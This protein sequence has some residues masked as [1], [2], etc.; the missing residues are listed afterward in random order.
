MLSPLSHPA[1]EI[2]RKRQQPLDVFFEPRNVALIGASETPGSVGRTLLQNLRAS[3][4]GGTVFPVNLKRSNV[5]GIKAY[6]S[7]KKLPEPADL[8]VIATPAPTVPGLIEECVAA[9]VKAAIIISAGFKEVG[10]AGIELEHT[11]LKTARAGKLRLIGPNCLGVMRPP[12]G[13]NATFANGIAAPGSVAFISQSG[14]LCTSILDWS[15]KENVGF[16]AFISVGS[17]LDVGWGDLID[18]LGDDPQTKSIL[19]YM[20]SIGDARA[21]LSAAR[22]VALSKPI[23]VIKAGRTEQAAKAA[24]SHTGSLAGSDAVLDAAFRRSGVLRVNRI[25]DLFYMAEVLAKQPRPHGPRLMILTNAGGPGVLATDAVIGEGLQLASLSKN[26]LETLNNQLPVAWSHSNPIDLLGDAPPERFR[27]SIQVVAK[28]ANSDGLLVILTPQAMTDPTATAQAVI[29]A[30]RNENK[31]LLTSWMGGQDVAAAND[32][33]AKAHIPTFP[34]PDTAVRAF[35]YM[36]RYTYNLRGLYETPLGARESDEESPRH[37]DVQKIFRSVLAD[38]RTLLTEVEAKRV[39]SAYGLPTVKTQAAGSVAEAVR[40][41]DKQGY[42]VVVKLLSHRITHKSDVGGVQLN[43]KSASEV[44]AA[45]ERIQKNVPDKDF[46][47]VSVQAMVP[48]QGFE[49][50]LGS[51]IDPQFGPVLLFGLGGTLVEVFKDRA[52]ALPPLTTVLARRMMEQTQVYTALK[53]IRG[54]KSVDLSALE[55]LLVQFS[56]LVSEHPRIKEIDINPLQAS[57]RGI[58]ALDAR[59]VIHPSSLTDAQLP[60]PAIRP[61]PQSYVWLFKSKKGARYTLRPIRPEDE[62]L[63]VR[64]HETLS[65]QSVYRR[66]LHQISLDQRTAHERLIRVC[67]NDYDR[68]LALVAETRDPQTKTRVLG[69]IARLIKLPHSTEGEI[70]VLIGDPFQEQ[71]LGSELVR[72]L[73]EMAQ[74]EGLNQV[75]ADILPENLGMQKVCSKLG[76]QLSHDLHDSV[77]RAVLP[78]V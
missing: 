15:R 1:H 43:L 37:Q 25:S 50:I 62:P 76:F 18:Y 32:L 52:L 66:Y 3:P 12:S 67:F 13:L 21:F 65:E 53:G 29:A 24:A 23:L 71:G 57:A 41:A 75:T 20:E 58:I 16:S 40:L 59:I 54:Q 36:W 63:V 14:A 30:Q 49:L 60:R 47:G 35:S 4:F 77:L 73:I 2:L 64:F 31:P 56:E 19:I 74:K 22:E 46:Q 70:S 26:T 51:S 7:L 8:A 28:E 33:L 69:G 78:L 39:L 10:K 61:Y 5:L 68:E 44:R 17:M 42:P 38:Q 9:G 11:V 34:Y 45:F 55:H 48:A 27:E 6:P 72:R